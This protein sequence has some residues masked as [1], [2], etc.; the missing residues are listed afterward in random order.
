MYEMTHILYNGAKKYGEDNWRKI[1]VEDHLNHMIA[2]A[3]AYLSGDTTT[4]HLANI[5]CRA[6]FAQ[7]RAIMDN[8][9]LQRTIVTTGDYEALE[10]AKR[11]LQETSRRAD[12][13]DVGIQHKCGHQLLVDNDSYI[14]CA[15]PRYHA[16]DIHRSDTNRLW[17]SGG[18]EVSLHRRANEF[19][20][21]AHR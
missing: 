4:E 9:K 10:Q 6:M 14:E 18:T 21:E 19:E 3:Y 7:G 11:N 8:A 17:T 15:L 1:P 12:E 20:G 16:D 2:H 5:M 13:F